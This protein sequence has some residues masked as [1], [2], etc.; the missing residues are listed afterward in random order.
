KNKF[1]ILIQR[2]AFLLVVSAL[3]LPFSTAYAEG[4]AFTYQGR[5]NDGGGPV[6]G[7]YDI[8]FSLVGV[9]RGGS[10]LAGPV[11]N[12]AVVVPHGM[13]T[14][15]LDFAASSPGAERWLELA[16]R[17]NGV[18]SFTTLAPRQPL[19]PTPYAITA[20]NIMSGGLAGTYGNILTF[21]NSGNSFNG[22]YTGNGAGISNV[23][24]LTLG[25]LG[26]NQF[27]KITGNS[28]TVPGANY[29]GTADN[30][31]LELRVNRIRALRIEPNISG[32]PSLIGGAPVNYVS[33]G[34]AGATI[35]GGGATN[36][37][38]GTYSNKVTADFGAV[39]GGNDNT[40][41]A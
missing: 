18:G 5:L 30:Q 15:R 22:T 20:G 35:A 26:A 28:N 37:F 14:T 7:S 21:S 4:T 29:L 12:S 25:G 1:I 3:Q 36:F 13:S 33:P 24:A 39:S 41:S 8:T 6:N 10:A 11:T 19:K 40:A 38:G 16:V 31:P 23:N 27:W 17:T 2:A 34:T 9:S 32:A